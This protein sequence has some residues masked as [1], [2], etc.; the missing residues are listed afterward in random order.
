MNKQLILAC[1]DP[2]CLAALANTVVPGWCDCD[3]VLCPTLQCAKI[4]AVVCATAVISGAF[5]ICSRHCVHHPCHA[6]VPGDGYN[7]GATVYIRK[8]G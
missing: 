4:A 8:E 2:F 1:L 3:V 6:V 5:G 7:S